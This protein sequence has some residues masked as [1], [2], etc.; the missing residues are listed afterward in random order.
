[1]SD[2]SFTQQIDAYH[3]GELDAARR[4]DVERHL[5]QC[6][7]CAAALERLRSMSRWFADAPAPRLS[8]ISLQRLHRRVDAVMDEGLLWTARILSGI[9][10]AVLIVGSIWLVHVSTVP[11]SA[12]VQ[13]S[14]TPPWAGIPASASD[15][16]L[17]SLSASTPAAQ[18]YLTEN[19]SRTEQLP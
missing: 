19:S 4:A 18:W 6:A 14:S 12:V 3:D 5:A 11:R 1:M 13:V 8:Q 7:D 2:C 16:E 17:T 10:A 15:A 9:A